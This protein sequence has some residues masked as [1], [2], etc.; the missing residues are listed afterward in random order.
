M[1][2]WPTD[3]H[4]CHQVGRGIQE[5][6]RGLI[7]FQKVAQLVYDSRAF[8]Q[9]M[10]QCKSTASPTDLEARNSSLAQRTAMATFPADW[11]EFRRVHGQ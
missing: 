3:R 6:E 1:S 10:S 2:Q 7:R 9:D 5:F 4:V 11:P 8:N